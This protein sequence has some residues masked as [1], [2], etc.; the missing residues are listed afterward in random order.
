MR[1]MS[2]LD[3][4]DA[5]D[6]LRVGDESRGIVEALCTSIPDVIEASTGYPAEELQGESPRELAKLL[7]MFQLQLLFSPDGTDSDRLRRTVDDLTFA[8]NA[9]MTTKEAS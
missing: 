2:W 8:L 7:A 1:G 5:L 6:H 9:L 4:A 3:I